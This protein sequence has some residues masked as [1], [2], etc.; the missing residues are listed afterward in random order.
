MSTELKAIETVYKGNRYRSRLEARWAVFYETLGIPY[1]YEPQG[2][3]LGEAGLYLPDFWLPEHK[4]FVEIKGT[5]PDS[6][7]L[8]IIEALAVQSGKPV[9]LF[10]GQIEEFHIQYEESKNGLLLRFSN[11]ADLFTS[12]GFKYSQYYWTKC[13]LCGKYDISYCG[14]V[15]Y[16]QDD[17]RIG[18]YENSVKIAYLKAK[19]ARFEHGERG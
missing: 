9:F 13:E 2:Y 3:N 12:N 18:A 5:W 16:C 19:Q 7:E 4:C 17:H 1:E 8:A 15:G 6:K 14:V 10:V 11:D